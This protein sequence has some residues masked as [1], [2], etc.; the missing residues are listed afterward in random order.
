MAK[1]EKFNWAPITEK[2]TEV[3]TKKGFKKD[4]RFWTPDKKKAGTY[5]I[6]FL[7][8]AKG[9]KNG[10]LP[11]VKLLHHAFKY[12][13]GGQTKWWIE[14]CVNTFGYDREC[15]ICAKSWEYKDSNFEKD[16]KLAGEWC[17]KLTY[18]SNILVVKNTANPE[19]EGK[20]FL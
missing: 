18:I 4:E 2:V 20:V 9:R 10:D 8:D 1:R 6:R 5:I 7:P 15:P 13:A 11:F 3:N 14:N 17:R 12:I 19:D 16:K